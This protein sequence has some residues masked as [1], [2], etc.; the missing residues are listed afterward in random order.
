MIDKKKQIED[1]ACVK[2][3]LETAIFSLFLRLAL[4]FLF[5][6]VLVWDVGLQLSA[7]FPE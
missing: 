4:F 1:D 6:S 7:V 2:A 3:S 5:E